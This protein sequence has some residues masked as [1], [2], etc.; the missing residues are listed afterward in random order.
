M[1]QAYS[2]ESFPFKELLKQTNLSKK[3]SQVKNFG[4]QLPNETFLK[5]NEFTG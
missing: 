3:L 1:K 2:I 4:V 5:N